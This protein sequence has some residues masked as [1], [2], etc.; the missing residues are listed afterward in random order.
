MLFSRPDDA[1]DMD[2]VAAVGVALTLLGLAGYAAGIATP[3][4]G[5]AFAVTGVMV[6]LTLVAVGGGA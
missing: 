5:R 4:P 3:Y 6:G 1:G 2:R